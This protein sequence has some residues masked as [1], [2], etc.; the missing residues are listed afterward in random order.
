MK[1]GSGIIIY[2]ACQGMDKRPDKNKQLAKRVEDIKYCRALREFLRTFKTTPCPLNEEHRI[3]FCHH[4]HSPKDRRRNPYN[5]AGFLY[6]LE[7]QCNCDNQV[8]QSIP[9]FAPGITQTMNTFIIP[10]S[11]KQ[12]SAPECL[13]KHQPKSAGCCTK[14]K[15]ATSTKGSSSD[16]I[17]QL[18]RQYAVLGLVLIRRSRPSRQKGLPI[19]PLR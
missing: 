17:S 8:Q 18:S 14:D 13:A 1:G 19:L 16:L 9:S 2:I 5:G 3:Q 4:Y 12:V 11:T 15:Q 10:F 7:H 6:Y